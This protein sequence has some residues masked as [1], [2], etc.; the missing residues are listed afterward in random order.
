MAYMK[1]ALG[2][3]GSIAA[4]RSP[5]FVKELMAA[6]HEVQVVLSPSAH[7]FVAP[8]VLETLSARRVIESGNFSE[9]N[10]STDHISLSRWAELFF[11]YAAS[12]ETLARLANGNA[13]DALSLQLL[14][15]QGQVLVAPAMNP[16]MWAHPA[17]VANVKRLTEFGYK[18]IGPVEGVV[19]CGERGVGHI[20][21]HEEMLHAIQEDTCV[22]AAT[23]KNFFCEKTVL[24]S[25]G[26]MQSSID[27]MRF[28]QNRSS[29]VSALEVSRELRSR[30]AKVITLLGPVDSLVRQEFL[31]SS[32]ELYDFKEVAEYEQLLQ[33]CFNISDVFVSMAAVLDFSIQFIPEKMSRSKIATM[34]NLNLSVDTVDDFVA[35]MSSQKR[36]DQT[37]IAF[38][39][40]S[41]ELDLVKQKAFTKLRSKQVDFIVANPL[42]STYG[43]ERDQTMFY[44]FDGRRQL[45]GDNGVDLGAGSKK[46]MAQKLVKYFETQLSSPS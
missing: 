37:V 40:E 36:S 25:A 7:H 38:A 1:I 11:V 33:K 2:V 5:D 17:V 3:S 34:K 8:K 18:L 29:G 16:A 26:P 15:F 35:L 10:F 27:P 43:A 45:E 9:T 19:A 31:K 13:S 4:Y 42:N 46:V 24:I 23:H 39:A 44:V 30:G 28:V 20:A 32:S 14:A 21:T 6:G 12:A 22:K 41:G